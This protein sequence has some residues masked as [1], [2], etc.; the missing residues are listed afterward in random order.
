M[1][2][3]AIAGV[4]TAARFQELVDWM[5]ERKATFRD[6]GKW[7]ETVILGLGS[8]ALIMFGLLPFTIDGDLG[9]EK[10]SLVLPLCAPW[11]AGVRVRDG[12]ALPQ[13][14]RV[15]VLRRHQDVVVAHGGGR[16]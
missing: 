9:L 11:P 1:V 13:R 14:R 3:V 16:I 6:G 12:G 7:T 4:T 2:R 8:P 15:M 10:P 5:E